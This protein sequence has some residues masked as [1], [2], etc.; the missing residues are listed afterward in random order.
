MTKSTNKRK[1][2]NEIPKIITITAQFLQYIS[3]KAATLFAAKLFSTP[4]KHKIPSRELHMEQ[5]SVQKKLL[6]PK[7]NKEIV[8]YEYGT[9]DKLILLV[10][11]WSGRGTQLVK[12]ADELLKNNYKVISFDAPAHGKSS[13]RTTLMIEFIECIMEIQ[14]LHSPFY[15][16]IG[17]S[18]GGMAIL[19]AK[20]W[21]LKVQKMV[22]I[23]AGNS[24]TEITEQFVQKLGLHNN[25]V[26]KLKTFFE[27]KYQL[28]MNDF[29]SD[30]NAEKINIPVFVIHD[31]NDDEV[32]VH[33]AYDIKNS[34]QNS[35]LLITQNLGHRKILGDANVINRIN[36]F[37]NK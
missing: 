15:A 8:V 9:G 1:K 21:G 2:T 11:G 6:I 20:N 14:K 28:K 24:I 16:A 32:L 35:E 27:K 5:N 10:H 30:I 7:I 26:D 31:E 29:A 18:L 17:H 36:E 23:G 19:N 37:I 12:I 4:L 34:L 3:P 22:T 33:C 13:S 25:Q